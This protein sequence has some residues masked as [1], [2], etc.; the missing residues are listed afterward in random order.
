VLVAAFLQLEAGVQAGEL[1][2]QE[3]RAR[4]EPLD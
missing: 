4:Q 3:L 1:V 2:D